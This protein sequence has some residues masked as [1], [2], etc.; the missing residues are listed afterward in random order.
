VV[1][2][3]KSA[4]PG[5]IGRSAVLPWPHDRILGGVPVNAARQAPKK[6]ETIRPN[7]LELGLARTVAW[8]HNNGA[9]AACWARRAALSLIR[10]LNAS[11]D[12]SSAPDLYGDATDSTAV[13]TGEVARAGA[14]W[15][16]A[17]AVGPCPFGSLGWQGPWEFLSQ[18]TAAFQLEFVRS[19]GSPITRTFP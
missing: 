2:R 18:I 14:P 5:A 4:E 10:G 3:A 9:P 11:E 15:G 1:E 17:P 7:L 8:P 13:A 12:P 6:S 19:P 16:S